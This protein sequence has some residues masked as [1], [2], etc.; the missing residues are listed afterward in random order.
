MIM[1]FFSNYQIA[2]CILNVFPLSA[3]AKVEE[4]SDAVGT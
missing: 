4:L 1:K 3:G 2:K